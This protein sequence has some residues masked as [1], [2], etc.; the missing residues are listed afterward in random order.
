MTIPFKQKEAVSK[1]ASFL[2]I[3]ESKKLIQL[4]SFHQE[5]SGW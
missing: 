5:H 3:I 4:Y 2:F 1:A